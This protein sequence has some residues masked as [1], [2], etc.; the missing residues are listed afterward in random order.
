MVNANRGNTP[1]NRRYFK[2]QKI[3][4]FHQIHSTTGSAKCKYETCIFSVYFYRFF[5]GGKL[6]KMQ[7]DKERIQ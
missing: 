6:V 7:T 5:T 3:S 2:N 4:N 1:K